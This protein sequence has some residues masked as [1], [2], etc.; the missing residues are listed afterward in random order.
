MS[1]RDRSHA[2][3]VAPE[4][5]T[6]ETP[7]AHESQE[8]EAA[9][10]TERRA[11]G[12]TNGHG[13]DASSSAMYEWSERVV[14]F[15]ERPVPGAAMPEFDPFP[16]PVMQGLFWSAV[17]GAVIGLIVAWLLRSGTVVL[18]GIEGIYSLVPWTFYWFFLLAGSAVGLLVG[19]VGALLMT[20]SHAQRIDSHGD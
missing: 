16:G 11:G 19:G 20:E 4:P 2:P 6:R 14:R 15:H 12:P 8:V 3:A 1:S 10:G 13:D 9:E 5:G 7:R 17:V 18:G